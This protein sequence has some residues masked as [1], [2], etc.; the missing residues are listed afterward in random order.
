MD[1]PNPDSL[2]TADRAAVRDFYRSRGIVPCLSTEEF[3]CPHTDECS[4][5]A[6]HRNAEFHT[7][8]WPYVLRPLMVGPL[9][10]FSL[11]RRQLMEN[12]HLNASNPRGG[13]KRK[14]KLRGVH[15]SPHR[16]H[17]SDSHQIVQHL[18]FVHISC[19]Q[20]QLHA[21]QQFLQA[22]VKETVRVRDYADSH[23]L[24]L[25][26][27]TNVASTAIMTKR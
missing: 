10:Q 15:V 8:T 2:E 4:A 12:L 26:A 5:T 24:G 9:F 3:G 23:Q 27:K 1:Y 16:A 14:A 22:R 20:D 7:G 21:R 13:T 19:M 6:R 11:G 18:L 25:S 17:R